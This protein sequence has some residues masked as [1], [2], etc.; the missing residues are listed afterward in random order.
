MT[1]Q[2]SGFKRVKWT[3]L[4]VATFFGEVFY[5]NYVLYRIEASFGW[6]E[7]SWFWKIFVSIYFF[8]CRKKK[9]ICLLIEPQCLK[10][11]VLVL[12]FS[13]KPLKSSPHKKLNNNLNRTERCHRQSHHHQKILVVLLYPQHP[14]R[15]SSLQKKALVTDSASA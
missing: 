8:Y 13:F 4:R 14:F 10:N 1:G 12:H 9:T 11:K 15:W 3:V 7:L 6:S 2:R 5:L